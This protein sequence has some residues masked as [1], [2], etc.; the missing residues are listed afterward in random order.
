MK[1]QP[2]HLCAIQMQIIPF[3]SRQLL[4]KTSR[5]FISHCELLNFYHHFQFKIYQFINLMGYV[6]RNIFVN[7]YSMEWRGWHGL[8]G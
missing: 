4:I 2:V 6:V 8:L 3:R 5:T 7:R 1:F